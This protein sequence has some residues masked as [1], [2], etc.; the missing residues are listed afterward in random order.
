M[1][2]PVCVVDAKWNLPA[3]DSSASESSTMKPLPEPSRNDRLPLL[4][5]SIVAVVVS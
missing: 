4:A 2:V 1:Y 3:R 5:S